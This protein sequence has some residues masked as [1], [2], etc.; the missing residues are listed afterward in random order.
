M[1][2]VDLAALYGLV[3]F[4]CAV[5]V[6]LRPAAPAQRVV[7]AGL[8]ILFWPLYGPFL[9]ARWSGADSGTAGSEVAF[10]A[11]LRRAAGTPLAALLPDERAARLLARRLRVAAAKVDE[12]DSLLRRPDFDEQDAQRRLADLQ[13]RCASDNA[14]A[15][16]ASRIQNIRRLRALRDRFSRELDELDE[17]LK[18]LTT[19]AE[20]VRL[21]GAPDRDAQDLV[22]EIVSRVEGLDHVLEDD[23]YASGAGA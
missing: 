2:L 4:G 20:V 13:Q 11:A 5:V 10:L 16:A 22:R 15:T 8:V 1:R 7:D 21:A 17:L 6:A 14:L 23:T 9:L 19:Q 18:Q 3:G 12:I